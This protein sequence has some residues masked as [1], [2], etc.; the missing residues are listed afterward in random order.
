MIGHSSNNSGGWEIFTR[1]EEVG[2]KEWGAWF[3]NG[4]KGGIFKVSLPSWQRS[5]NPLIL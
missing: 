4:G 5:A 1:N 3:Y 2:N